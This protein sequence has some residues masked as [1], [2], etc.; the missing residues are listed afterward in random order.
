MYGARL[1]WADLPAHVHLFVSDVLGSPVVSARTQPAGFSPGSADRVVT[2]AGA[3]AF[4]KAVNPRQNPDTPALHRREAT[5]LPSLAGV[6]AV[7]RLLA[8]HD[9][10]EWVVLVIED[11][12][13][14]HP[15]LPWSQGELDLTF[16]AL[17]QLATVDAPATWPGLQEELQGEFSCWRRVI[18]DPPESLDPWVEV[19]VEELD[20][21]ARRTLPR[22][23]GSAVAHTDLRA[24][25]LL[26][27]GDGAVRVVDWP[28]ASRGAPWFDAVSLLVNVRWSGELDV[29]PSLP[30]ITDLGATRTDVLGTL[31]GLGGF[32]LDASRR[33][34]KPGLPTLRVFQAEQW[35]ATLR[36]LQELGTWA[37]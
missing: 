9:D 6:G 2:A 17:A 34:A 10:G 15:R 32:L 4:V 7:P 37:A 21:L 14:R 35:R 27:E 29:R 12:E 33:P 18:E 30:R 13:G 1:S 11:V 3:R 16:D 20:D 22:L 24:D 23:G 8:V 31:A 5:V 19:R 26:I 36:L 25:N 28:W